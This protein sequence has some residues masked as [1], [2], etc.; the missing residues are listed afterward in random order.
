MSCISNFPDDA[1]SAPATQKLPGVLLTRKV[2]QEMPR[3]SVL[4]KFENGSEIS[5]RY[6]Y[7]APLSTT[8][9]EAIEKA[10]SFVKAAL[11]R[12]PTPLESWTIRHHF[13]SRDLGGMVVA[14]GE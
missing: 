8:R 3:I 12:I 7:G 10:K 11:T 1:P 2:K 5:E 14:R 13:N 6:L 9:Y 4:V